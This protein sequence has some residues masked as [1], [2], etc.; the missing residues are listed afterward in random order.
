M[1]YGGIDGIASVVHEH[2][3]RGVDM[4]CAF[5][6]HLPDQQSVS[7]SLSSDPLLVLLLLFFCELL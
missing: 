4:R 7:Q 2:Q 5:T 6:G 3:D 1:A